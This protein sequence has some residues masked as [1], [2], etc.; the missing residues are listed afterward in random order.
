MDSDYF[1]R[2]YT[3][4]TDVKLVK[5]FTLVRHMRKVVTEPVSEVPRSTGTT[6][7]GVY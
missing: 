4:V 7:T 6:V 2:A 5:N 1:G 3:T